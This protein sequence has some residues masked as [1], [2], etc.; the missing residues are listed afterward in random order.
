MQSCIWSD[1]FQRWKLPEVTFFRTRL[2]P[3]G[4][5]SNYNESRWF[6]YFNGKILIELTFFVFEKGTN[7]VTHSNYETVIEYAEETNGDRLLQVIQV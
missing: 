3:A 6:F 2:P 5:S 1:E 7:S 4:Q